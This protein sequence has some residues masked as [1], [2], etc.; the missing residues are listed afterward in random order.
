M[1]T[2]PESES[3]CHAAMASPKIWSMGGAPPGPPIAGSTR[4]AIG[5]R[6]QNV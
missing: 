5:P 3:D 2:S 1:Q 4:S 6:G